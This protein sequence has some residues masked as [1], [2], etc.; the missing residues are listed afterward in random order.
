L[1]SC[2]GSSY[3]G[4]GRAKQAANARDSERP[5]VVLEESLPGALSGFFDLRRTGRQASEQLNQGGDVAIRNMPTAVKT[6][7]DLRG[8]RFGRTD[9]EDRTAGGH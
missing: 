1:R 2:S 9:E 5:I 8:G 3:F 4:F 7:D 6:P